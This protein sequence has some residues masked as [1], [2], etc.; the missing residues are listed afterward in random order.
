[1][2][3]FGGLA[4]AGELVLPTHGVAGLLG[5]GA[6]AAAL[7]A[8]LAATR[9]L[10]PEELARLRRLVTVVRRGRRPAAA[11]PGGEPS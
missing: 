3:V 8:A 7:P 5:R 10:H 1:V 4:A 11:S 6:V 2:L 9:F